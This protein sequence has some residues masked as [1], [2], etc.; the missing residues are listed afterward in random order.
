MPKK[1]CVTKRKDRHST[2]HSVDPEKIKTF[3]V[4]VSQMPVFPNNNNL[5]IPIYPSTTYGWRNYLVWILNSIS[6]KAWDFTSLFTSLSRTSV[7]EISKQ[8]QKAIDNKQSLDNTIITPEP[9]TTLLQQHIMSTLCKIEPI[10]LELHL[11][12]GSEMRVKL[13]LFRA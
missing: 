1:K 7:L 2:G 5:P 13:S 9:V 10:L 4:D 8:V 11:A 3:I 12:V 6:G